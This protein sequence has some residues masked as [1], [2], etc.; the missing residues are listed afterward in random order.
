MTIRVKLTL[1][2]LLISAA[3]GALS[4]W[5]NLNAVH[6]ALVEKAAGDAALLADGF[7]AGVLE[8]PGK[9]DEKLL[10]PPLLSLMK[11]T[12]ALYAAALDGNGKILAHSDVT[13]AGK[14]SGDGFTLKALSSGAFLFRETTWRGQRIIKLLVPV[15]RPAGTRGEDF[16]LSTG[17]GQKARLGTL[18]LGLSAG[19]ILGLDAEITARLAGIT[20]SAFFLIVL[21]VLWLVTRVTKP[22]QLLNRGT[23]LIK[24]GRYGES[25]PVASADELGTLTRNFNRMSAAL[26]DTAAS[27]NYLVCLLNNIGDPIIGLDLDARITRVNP[28]AGRL[29]GYAEAELIG[30]KAAEFFEVEQPAHRDWTTGVVSG[31]GSLTSLAASLRTKTGQTIPILLSAATVKDDAGRISGLVA[32]AKDITERK[33]AEG[34]VTEAYE[35]QQSL[36]RMLRHS[37]ANLPLLDKLNGQ[38]ASLFKVPWLPLEP[39]GA[40]FLLAAGGKAMN[41]AVQHGLPPAL[42]KACASAAA[43]PPDRGRTRGGRRAPVIARLSRPWTSTWASCISG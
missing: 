31:A 42:L 41:L 2:V 37:V 12:N 7:P 40:I 22:I 8:G 28:A 33:L 10:L 36:N 4:L 18:E 15:L 35:M 38:L 30:K 6:T 21:A 29:L 27:T 19:E 32:V 13:E 16:L 34:A 26:K 23:E 39:R 14:T 9:K 25:I 43:P 20:A 24:E 3:S 1:A 5:F 11:R 17:V